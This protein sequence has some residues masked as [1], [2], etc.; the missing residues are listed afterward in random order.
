[1][2]RGRR[3]C[4]V[5]ALA[6]IFAPRAHGAPAILRTAG[7]VSPLGWPYSMFS[8]GTLD[9]GGRLV[10]VAS[11]TAVFGQGSGLTQRVGA[12]TVIPDGRRVINV[13]PPSLADDGCIITRV[14]FEQG[15]EA[16]L[17]ACGTTFTVLADA[18]ATAPG[19]G[20]IRAFDPVVFVRGTDLVGC[21]ATLDDGTSIL[22]RLGGAGPVEVV[23]SG[24][25]APTGGIFAS[26]RFLGM[27]AAG[28]LGF[29][30]TVS[31]GPDGL[32]AADENAITAIALVGDSSPAGGSFS[33]LGGGSINA[34]DHW[35]FRASLSS[36]D[37]GIFTVDATPPIPLLDALVLQGATAPMDG[38]TIRSFPGSIDPSIDAA[39]AVAF[40][41]L[42]TGGTS[43]SAALVAA[44]DGTLSLLAATRVD[45]GGGRMIRQ[46][47]DPV[48][49][50]D[51]SAVVSAVIAGEGPGLFATRPGSSLDPIARLGDATDVDTGDARFRFSA[52]SVTT[53]A[54]S[55]VVF[56]QRDAIFRAGPTDVEAIV[57]TGRPTPLGGKFAILGPPV[58]D[59]H[60]TVFVGAEIQG[61]L[62]NEALFTENP[63]GIAA[64]VSPDRRL[65]GGGGIRELFPT[66]V[67]SLARPAAA[68]KGVVFTAAL[69][70]AK[71]S[72]GLFGFKTR[73]SMKVVARTGQRAGG[74]RIADLGTPTADRGGRVALLAELGRDRKRLGVVVREGGALRVLTLVGVSTRTRVQGV[75]ATLGPPAIARRGTVFRATLAEKSTEGLFIGK[76]G[77]IGA[78]VAS[79]DVTQRG[80][81]IRT[82]DDPIAIDDEVYFLARVA[83]SVAPAGLY[84]VRVDAIPR[85]DDAAL[86]IEPV[87]LPGDPVPPPLGGVVVR[88]DAPRV[89]FAGAVTAVVEAGGGTASSAI[90]QIDRSLP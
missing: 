63:S 35:A 23:R 90:V 73:K 61:G 26:F 65:L 28:R 39:G 2:R 36:G 1:M 33:T 88:V 64:F 50:D 83:G 13:S 12:G 46:L 31:D 11:S 66:S 18:G 44:P 57:Y 22:M 38:T 56:G 19:G 77:R 16:I 10:F 59:G 87:L 32:F 69:Q 70:G 82:V 74:E 85:R 68:P 52:V 53:A 43:G 60:D 4:L 54:E 25:P 89:G 84:R 14:A 29:R 75:F 42:L 55:A 79:G 80:D 27:S 15:G 62:F 5:L 47:R 72:E 41:A 17:R 3:L 8:E 86:A 9:R 51:G 76:G 24:R 48:L 78:V 67:D 71:A 30:A 21:G 49:A 34:S 20:T 37:A 40:R 45:I 6:A 58:V 81:R 7:G